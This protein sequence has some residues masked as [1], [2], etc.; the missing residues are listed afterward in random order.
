MEGNN[1]INTLFQAFLSVL[2]EK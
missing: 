2:C 1:G